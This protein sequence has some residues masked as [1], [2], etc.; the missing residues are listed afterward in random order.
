[1][2]AVVVLVVR[3]PKQYAHGIRYGYDEIRSADKYAQQHAFGPGK[4]IH[5]KSICIN[6]FMY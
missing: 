4:A 5:L 1:M 6:C 2:A 3:V